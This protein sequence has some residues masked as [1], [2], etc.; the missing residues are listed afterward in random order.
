MSN[1]SSPERRL[2]SAVDQ[3]SYDHHGHRKHRSRK[4]RHKER[5]DGRGGVDH[6]PLTGSE[7]KREHRSSSRHRHK[8]SKHHHHKRKEAEKFSGENLH[9][10]TDLTDVPASSI[11]PTKML[12]RA[13]KDKEGWVVVGNESASC[14]ENGDAPVNGLETDKPEHN[15][16]VALSARKLIEDGA[17]EQGEKPHKSESEILS[18]GT[19][20]LDEPAPGSPLH[21]VRTPVQ[22]T[23]T[24]TVAEP[25]TPVMDELLVPSYPVPSNNEKPI[26]NLDAIRT[27]PCDTGGQEKVKNDTSRAVENF[28]DPGTPTMD[29]PVFDSGLVSSEGKEPVTVGEPSTRV[30]QPTND[31]EAENDG[32]NSIHLQNKTKQQNED[33]RDNDE[34]TVE[35]R[36]ESE[37]KPVPGDKNSSD[38][39]VHDTTTNVQEELSTSKVVDQALDPESKND[40]PKILNETSPAGG[41]QKLETGTD[42]KSP[43]ET[44]QCNSKPMKTDDEVAV[45]S[46]PLSSVGNAE[47]ESKGTQDTATN[48][49]NSSSAE[50]GGE[51]VLKCE[52]HKNPE[53]I[54]KGGNDEGSFISSEEKAGGTEPVKRTENDIQHTS[55]AVENKQFHAKEEPDV[56]LESDTV[57]ERPLNEEKT[58]QDQ[59][60]LEPVEI[61]KPD[62]P[63]EP[64]KAETNHVENVDKPTNDGGSKMVGQNLPD[65]STNQ[66]KKSDKETKLDNEQNH[67]SVEEPQQSGLSKT[68]EKRSSETSTCEE[69]AGENKER[70]EP[71][72]GSEA[73]P[74]SKAKSGSSDKELK[75]PSKDSSSSGSRQHSSSSSTQKHKSG[76]Y[77]VISGA[78]RGHLL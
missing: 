71:V 55:N 78:C 61:K 20:V 57:A 62:G 75:N 51:N 31:K 65:D 74:N 46:V 39:R 37:T 73:V 42:M 44:T 50:K 23:E 77:P 26:I 5:E 72:A 34:E 35:L 33:H 14:V 6:S 59:G 49:Q 8:H 28:A 24:A 19:P 70:H 17:K 29:E 60:T 16:V 53:E 45:E 21:E 10:E 63:A 52:G 38:E 68:P 25:S 3:S 67:L 15:K 11:S 27:L 41:K 2:R 13:C 7:R 22:Q 32:G 69:K 30:I 43:D 76:K 1:G 40:S 64:E 56:V 54:A 9:V 18:P 47:F 48:T 12:I 36:P 4:H 58:M 66:C